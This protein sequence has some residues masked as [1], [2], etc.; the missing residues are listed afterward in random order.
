MGENVSNYDILKWGKTVYRKIWRIKRFGIKEDPDSSPIV[1]SGNW[2]FRQA[3]FPEVNYTPD[4]QG[5]QLIP[6]AFKNF[7]SVQ[8]Y[9]VLELILQ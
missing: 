2:Y 9:F 3:T 1:G 4:K 7:A 8:K 6:E 5:I